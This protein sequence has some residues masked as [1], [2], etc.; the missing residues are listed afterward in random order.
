[1]SPALFS[2]NTRHFEA[3]DSQDVVSETSRYLITTGPKYEIHLSLR[4]YSY[5]TVSV[6]NF[7]VTEKCEIGDALPIRFVGHARNR[8]TANI[9]AERKCRTKTRV[10]KNI[11]HAPII[12]EQFNWNPEMA[13]ILKKNSQYIFEPTHTN[14]GGSFSI[15]L[16]WL[17]FNN[18]DG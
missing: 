1:M 18:C 6:I 16:C 11:K 8:T 4:F 14:K 2:T 12:K 3:I 9:E 7:Y 15:S 5:K 10:Y 13:Y 17:E